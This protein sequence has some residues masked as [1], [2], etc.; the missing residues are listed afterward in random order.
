MFFPRSLLLSYGFRPF[1][2]IKLQSKLS[3]LHAISCLRHI[4]KL[5]ASLNFVQFFAN[6]HCNDWLHLLLYL[7]CR[8]LLNLWEFVILFLVMLVF[9]LRDIMIFFV[10]SFSVIMNGGESIKYDMCNEIRSLRNK[11]VT[12]NR[13]VEGKFKHQ[14][15]FSPCFCVICFG[16][17]RDEPY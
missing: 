13:V 6:M 7:A 9:C 14:L 4:Y 12:K 5:V 10:L 11:S 8:R 17:F 15:N 2:S 3:S 1:S 16:D